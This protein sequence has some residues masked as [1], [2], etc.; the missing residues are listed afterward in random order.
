MQPLLLRENGHPDTMEKNENKETIEI[1]GMEKEGDPK[2]KEGETADQEGIRE[3]R[4]K[5]VKGR[6]EEIAPTEARTVRT[7]VNPEMTKIETI[8]KGPAQE[9]GTTRGNE[10]IKKILIKTDPKRSQK[11]RNLSQRRALA[12]FFP[13]FSGSNPPQG[14]KAQ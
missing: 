12:D 13:S 2:G 6:K 11:R 7:E 1:L 3:I 9:T 8:R 14:F 4:M 10:T 5:E